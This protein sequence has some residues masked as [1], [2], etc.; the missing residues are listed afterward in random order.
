MPVCRR[1]GKGMK[2]NAFRPEF[3][4]STAIVDSDSSEVREFV[5]RSLE[6]AQDLSTTGKAI[7]L[8]EAV[9]DGIRYDPFNIGTTEDDYRA[10]RIA[11][12]PSNYCVPKAILLAAA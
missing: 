2:P 8:F 4:V 11:G 6:S 5:V 12:T 10:S 1:R 7:R 3:L 9:R